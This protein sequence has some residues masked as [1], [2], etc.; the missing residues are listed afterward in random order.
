MYII[1]FSYKC[2]VVLNIKKYRNIIVN[3]TFI[4]VAVYLIQVKYFIVKFCDIT[5]EFFLW[6]NE[7]ITLLKLEVIKVRV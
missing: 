5:I 2:N 7:A 6:T 3:T 1:I 4:Y